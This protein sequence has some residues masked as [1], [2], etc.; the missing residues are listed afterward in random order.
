[1]VQDVSAGASVV[2]TTNGDMVKFAGGV[3]TRHPIGSANQILQV[4]SSL[5]SWE[6]ISFPDSVLT[7]QGDTLY[8]G[9]SGLARLAAGTSGYFLKTQGAS[10]NPV[11]AEVAGG[12]SAS[13]NITV[14]GVTLT[15]GE[16]L[17]LGI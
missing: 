6:T 15:L 12:A 14:D 17:E 3:R 7:T 4:K 11:W 5:P 16:W 9:A 13:D 1:M 8:E 2:M 10:A